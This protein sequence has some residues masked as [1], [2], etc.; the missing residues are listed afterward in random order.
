LLS[1]VDVDDADLRVQAATYGLEDEID[2]LLCYLET[3]GEV[4]DVWLPEYEEFQELA[5][6]YEVPLLQ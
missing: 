6:D 1:H 5:A 4:D 2:A 3:Q